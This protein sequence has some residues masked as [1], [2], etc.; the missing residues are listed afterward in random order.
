MVF[1]SVE[2]CWYLL[3]HYFKTANTFSHL[4]DWLC[5]EL[6]SLM[7]LSFLMKCSLQVDGNLSGCM[8]FDFFIWLQLE[9]T[10][11]IWRLLN[12]WCHYRVHSKNV[13]FLQWDALKLI[14]V[15]RPLSGMRLLLP[16]S[17]FIWPMLKW[18]AMHLVLFQVSCRVCTGT[19]WGFQSFHWVAWFQH[20][21]GVA[22]IS[23]K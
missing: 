23:G 18:F 13:L 9:L 15:E 11:I 7:N 20:S 12:P 21:Y 5:N 19:L 16:S 10:W 1:A 6:V 4:F 14:L 3:I 17:S 8:L 22:T 2:I